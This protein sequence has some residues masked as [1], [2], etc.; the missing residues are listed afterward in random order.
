MAE[1]Q[2]AEATR[3][4]H[5]R[6]VEARNTWLANARQL[7]AA[8]PWPAQVCRAM[9]AGLQDDVDLLARLLPDVFLNGSYIPQSPP[10]H[11]EEIASWFARAARS[12]ASTQVAVYRGRRS[13]R[14]RRLMAWVFEGG[15]TQVWKSPDSSLTQPRPAAVS[16]KGQRLYA[17]ASE[18]TDTEPDLLPTRFVGKDR[19]GPGVLMQMAD[20]AQLPQLPRR[21]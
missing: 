11:E 3:D 4:R 9:R 7:M 17:L 5:E 20:L 12:P 18:W 6:H 21:P 1:S 8:D 14:A 19:F 10:W 13:R 2:Q 15:S 16:I